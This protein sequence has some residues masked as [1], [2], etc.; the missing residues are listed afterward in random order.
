[1]VEETEVVENEVILE[2][3]LLGTPKRRTRGLQPVE[4]SESESP[5]EQLN[6]TS[7]KAKEIIEASKALSLIHI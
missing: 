2:E 5:T 1:M 4:E 6:Q 3:Q 7:S